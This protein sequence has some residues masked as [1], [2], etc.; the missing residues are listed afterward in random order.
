MVEK[1]K[2][3]TLKDILFL[4][5][6]IP[7]IIFLIL[8]FIRCITNTIEYKFLDLF[9]FVEPIL[10]FNYNF[11]II[12]IFIL[13]IPFCYIMFYVIDKNR[14]KEDNINRVRRGNKLLLVY[15]LSF[16]PYLYLIYSCIFGI[17]FG[18]MGSSYT[19]Y[20][21]DAIVIAFMYGCVILVYPIIIIFQIIYTIKNYKLFSNNLKNAVKIIIGLLLSILVVFSF[22]ASYFH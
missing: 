4:I 8:G 21:F 11:G 20:G 18:L 1:L 9:G 14:Y 22:L 16:I 12:S 3:L 6:L 13:F 5:S 17:E 19:Y 15:F 10:E 2:K 7:Y